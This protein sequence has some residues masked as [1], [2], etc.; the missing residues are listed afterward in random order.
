MLCVFFSSFLSYNCRLKSHVHIFAHSCLGNNEGWRS[1]VELTAYTC[2]DSLKR[3]LR[4]ERKRA[5]MCSVSPPIELLIWTSSTCGVVSRDEPGVVVKSWT[6][7]PRGGF[8]ALLPSSN[9]SCS[10]KQGCQEEE[11]VVVVGRCTCVQGSGE[12]LLS[13]CFNKNKKTNSFP[14]F[15]WAIN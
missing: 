1:R 12:K 14:L 10:E 2:I 6:T 13:S 9:P 15:S 4:E 8:N 7:G 3:W 11:E 5:P